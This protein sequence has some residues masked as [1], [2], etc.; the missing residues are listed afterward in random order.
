MAQTNISTQLR[1]ALSRDIINIHNSLNC[2]CYITL[3]YYTTHQ[4][5][6]RV[7]VEEKMV[8]CQSMEGA[9]ILLYTK[10]YYKINI[11]CKLHI[12]YFLET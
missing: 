3:H 12:F 11:M 2:T 1:N 5:Q 9:C 8:Q 6:Q 7:D 4:D 10:L